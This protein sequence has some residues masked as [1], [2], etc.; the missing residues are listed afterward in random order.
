MFLLFIYGTTFIYAWWL[1]DSSKEHNHKHGFF[2]LL[3]DL[4]IL[5]L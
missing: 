2:E 5:K 4:E 3:L 1:I